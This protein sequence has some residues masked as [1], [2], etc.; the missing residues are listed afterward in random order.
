MI[1]NR[2]FGRAAGVLAATALSV[3]VS[4]AAID[5]TSPPVATAAAPAPAPA[6]RVT[7]CDSS[8]YYVLWIVDYQ[9]KTTCFYGDG[10]MGYRINEV[11]DIHSFVSGWVR[12]Y[13]SGSTDGWEETLW[14]DGGADHTYPRGRDITQV[15]VHC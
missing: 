15:C 1:R 10:Y 14:N 4:V 6:V 8:S 13:N 11:R 5:V 2:K 7:S 12:M 9:G 3:A